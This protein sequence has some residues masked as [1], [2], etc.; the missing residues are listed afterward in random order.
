MPVHEMFTVKVDVIIAV[1]NADTTLEE[2]VRSAMHQ[3]IPPHLQTAQYNVSSTDTDVRRLICMSDIQFDVCVCCYDDASSDGSM[4]IL[5][6]LQEEFDSTTTDEKS[7]EAKGTIL[8]TKLLVGSAPAASGARGAG[9]ARNQAVKLRDSLHQ[10][11]YNELQSPQSPCRHYLCIL[12]SDDVMHPTRIAEQTSAVLSLGYDINKTHLSNKT[13]VGATFNRIPDDATWHYSQWANSLTDE[14]LYLEIF[15]ECTLVQPTWFLS[16]SWFQQL[17]CYVE[18]LA[19]EIQSDSAKDMAT[20][21][22][23]PTGEETKPAHDT[24]NNAKHGVKRKK[25]CDVDDT[26]QNQSTFDATL[27]RLIHSSEFLNTQNTGDSKPTNNTLRLAEDTRFFY[28]HLHA[29][30]RLHLHRTQT[31][32]VAYRHRCGMSQ[33]SNTP[34]KLLL[35]LRAKAWEDIV[36][37][38]KRDANANGKDDSDDDSIWKKRGFAIWGAG[39]DGKEFLKSLS[40]A[41]A[42]R[43][44]CFVDVDKKKIEQIKWYHNATLGF[45]IPILHFSDLGSKVDIDDSDNDN[46]GRIDKGRGESNNFDAV[47]NAKVVESHGTVYAKRIVGKSSKSKS[48]ESSICS[49]ILQNLPVVVCVAMYRTNGALESNVSSIGRVEGSN[50]WHIN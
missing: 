28:A 23:E 31:P 20:V 17:G 7:T 49:D 39:R 1:H 29:G 25:M 12:D 16:K 33:S 15:R 50:L 11:S 24:T 14:R 5:R 21:N 40:P 43:V 10:E 3:I 4:R 19:V 2:T 13:L 32:L 27:Y 22:R 44:V 18:A 46:F 37:Y 42:S 38:G 45:R 35:K 9:F 6:S 41:V 34:R 26:T 48:N 36:F 30:G 8:Q 47:K